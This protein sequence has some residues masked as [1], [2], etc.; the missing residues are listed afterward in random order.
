[1]EEINRDFLFFSFIELKEKRE[2]TKK[3]SFSLI[4]NHK[5]ITRMESSGCEES[6]FSDSVPLFLQLIMQN[7]AKFY[8]YCNETVKWTRNANSSGIKLPVKA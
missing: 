8:F 4:G 7:V 3:G 2:K 6:H 1:M 5:S